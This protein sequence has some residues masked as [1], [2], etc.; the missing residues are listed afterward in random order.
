M[1]KARSADGDWCWPRVCLRRTRNAG[2]LVWTRWFGQKRAGSI[3]SRFLEFL[4]VRYDLPVK[5]WK[6]LIQQVPVYASIEC[7]EGK[8]LEQCLT[9]E[10]YRRAARHLWNDGADGIYLFNFFTTREWDDQSFEP[11]FEVL[12][13]LG[14]PKTLQK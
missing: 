6:E 5:P 10:K 2:R 3:S 14:D 12:R 9:A 1:P 4:F 11:P 8:K 7:T 13:E